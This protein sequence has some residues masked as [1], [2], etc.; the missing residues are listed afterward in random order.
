MDHIWQFISLIL[1]T[2]IC[3]IFTFLYS[4][5][6]KLDLANQTFQKLIAQNLDKTYAFCANDRWVSELC[7]HSQLP[8]M[9]KI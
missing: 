9:L 4:I 2:G 5:L 1:K 7:V 6:C 3:Q 8:N